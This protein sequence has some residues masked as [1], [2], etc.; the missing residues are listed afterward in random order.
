MHRNPQF[1][2]SGP[3]T[4]FSDN[5][6][7]ISRKLVYQ[8]MSDSTTIQFNRVPDGRFERGRDRLGVGIV[9][10]DFDTATTQLVRF[11]LVQ[12]DI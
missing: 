6:V 7:S 4:D 3:M 12:L 10:L 5:P 2:Q 1:N 11:E 9:T 8:L